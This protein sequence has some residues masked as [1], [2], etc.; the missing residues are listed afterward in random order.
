MLRW[1]AIVVFVVLFPYASE[2]I[3]PNGRYDAEEMKE[4]APAAEL[5]GRPAKSY[6][7]VTTS[8]VGYVIEVR[9]PSGS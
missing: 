7:Y 3:G 1:Q 8:C 5:I 2:V 4:S 9:L 6:V